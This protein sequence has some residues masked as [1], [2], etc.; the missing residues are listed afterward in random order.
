MNTRQRFRETLLFGS[1]DKIPFIPGYPRKSTLEAWHSQGLDPQTDFFDALLDTLS[2]DP[3]AKPQRFDPGV[4]FKMIPEFE[5]TVLEHRDGHYLVQDWMGAIVEISDTFDYTFLRF[6]KDFVTRKWHRFPVET[7]DD[8]EEMKKRYSPTTEGRYPAD[9]EE[10]SR[11]L[12][13]SEAVVEFQVNG[14]FWQLREWCGFERLCLLFLEDP[15]FVREMIEFWTEFVLETMRGIF[16]KT[17]VDRV[18]ISEDMAYKAHSMISPAMTREF[19]LPT[20]RKW[21]T[22]IRAGGCPIVD[23][24]SDGY[25]AELIPIWIE[26]GINCCDP[27]EVAAGNDI[28]EYRKRFGKHIAYTGAIDKRAIAAGGAEMQAEVLRV[29]PPLLVEGGFIPSCDHGVPPDISWP[30]FLE[31]SRLL[32]QLTGWL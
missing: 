10:R 5:E 6:P 31:Y 4:S 32:A 3:A 30:N 12:N 1:P 29:V 20:Y 9:F 28:V 2:I 15:E 17:T 13:E 18:G 21:V 26:A 19:L 23:M 22:E 24:D 11:Q 14:P 7:R 27:I 25:V 8:W 16:A